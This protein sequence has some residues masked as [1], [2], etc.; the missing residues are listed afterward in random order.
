M[1]TKVRN[2]QVEWSFGPT[3]RYEAVSIYRRG[4]T[5]RYR[6]THK[7]TLRLNIAAIRLGATYYPMYAPHM[8]D[9]T[10]STA[11]DVY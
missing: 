9:K 2:I 1:P 11:V 5:G 6:L 7:R 10:C 3:G 4:H 8:L